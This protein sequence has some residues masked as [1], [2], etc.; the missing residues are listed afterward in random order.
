M[1]VIPSPQPEK[2]LDNL[3]SIQHLK[4]EIENKFP[5]V[6]VNVQFDEGICFIEF[7]QTNVPNFDNDIDNFVSDF[8]KT[9]TPQHAVY[10]KQF[11]SISIE[12]NAIA[13]EPTTPHPE[14]ITGVQDQIFEL[15]QDNG[16]TTI[17]KSI[18]GGDGFSMTIPE[19]TI[20]DPLAALIKN[21]GSN[22][23][24]FTSVRHDDGDAI[25]NVVQS[26]QTGSKIDNF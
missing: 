10:D 26:R 14:N 3:L 2:G 5:S 8:N 15:L 18:F 21:I 13:L 17:P 7:S 20:T 12:L 24:M 1:E 25:I 19:T 16:Y 9:Y 6:L 11:R 23:N 22:N 4:N